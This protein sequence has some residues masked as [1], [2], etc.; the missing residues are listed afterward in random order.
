MG[1]P[2]IIVITITGF[3][4]VMMLACPW[5]GWGA[6]QVDIVAEAK[7]SCA[8][9]GLILVPKTLRAFSWTCV[10]PELMHK[11]RDSKYYIV[12]KRSRAELACKYFYKGKLLAFAPAENL[13]ICE[14]RRKEKREIQRKKTRA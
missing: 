7:A 2:W 11:H 9:T 13:W 12:T 14:D 6:G 8:E 3:M 1:K 10:A 4:V 5:P